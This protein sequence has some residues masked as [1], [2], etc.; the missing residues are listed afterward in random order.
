MGRRRRRRGPAVGWL[1]ILAGVVIILALIRPAGVW[2]CALAV[3][4]II[5]GIWLLRSCR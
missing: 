1:V 3:A 4:L 2:W 5:G